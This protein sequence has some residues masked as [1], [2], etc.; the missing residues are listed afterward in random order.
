M[1]V[2]LDQWI[3]LVDVVIDEAID[4]GTSVI[5]IDQ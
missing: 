3:D 2:K 4:N 1:G 5:A